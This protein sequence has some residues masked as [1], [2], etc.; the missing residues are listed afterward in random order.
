MRTTPMKILLPSQERAIGLLEVLE[1]MESEGRLPNPK[2]DKMVQQAQLWGSRKTLYYLREFIDAEGPEFYQGEVEQNETLAEEAIRNLIN[3]SDSLNEAY[4]I[5]MSYAD[6]I[7]EPKIIKRLDGKRKMPTF[8]NNRLD[9]HS[10]IPMIWSWEKVSILLIPFD[11]AFSANTKP[12]L[13]V[14]QKAELVSP[15]ELRVAIIYRLK[16]LKHSKTDEYSIISEDLWAHCPKEE[17][18][19]SPSWLLSHGMITEDILD[20][21][22]DIKACDEPLLNIKV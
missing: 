3:D 21:L 9:I 16:K 14:I 22:C 13:K 19:E 5:I 17:A 4:S 20:I 10:E 12:L 15:H 2:L 8:I 11:L 7:P 18:L 1:K 6:Q